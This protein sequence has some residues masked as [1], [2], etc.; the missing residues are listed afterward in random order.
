MISQI[1][2]CTYNRTYIKNINKWIHELEGVFL[3]MIG[4]KYL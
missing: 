2:N 4:L 1:L 3:K